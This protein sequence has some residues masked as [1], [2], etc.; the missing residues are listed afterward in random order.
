V[1]HEELKLKM[2]H[3]TR[4]GDLSGEKVKQGSALRAAKHNIRER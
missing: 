4:A 2:E 3:F 1:F